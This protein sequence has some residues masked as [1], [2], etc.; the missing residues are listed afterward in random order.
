MATNASRVEEV[1]VTIHEPAFVR[2]MGCHTLMTYEDSFS[3]GCAE[4]VH[5]EVGALRMM[6]C[7]T[8]TS[9]ID[10]PLVLFK[11]V[12]RH[13]NIYQISQHVARSFFDYDY[14]VGEADRIISHFHLSLAAAFVRADD[15]NRDR[16]AS[17]FPEYGAAFL[18]WNKDRQEFYRHFG[19]DV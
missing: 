14:S 8:D 12:Q 5:N 16:L 11:T 17:A 7:G 3:N 15:H 1:V 18:M 2:C 13:F 10:P 9:E 6:C 4:G 19:L